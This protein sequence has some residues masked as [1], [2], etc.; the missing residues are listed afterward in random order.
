MLIEGNHQ[1]QW[2][3]KN[4][5]PLESHSPEDINLVCTLSQLSLCSYKHIYFIYVI[6]FIY[7][8]SY[9]YIYIYKINVQYICI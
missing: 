6:Y 3:I 4:L 5:P 2:L 9:G 8:Y 1:I 7:M